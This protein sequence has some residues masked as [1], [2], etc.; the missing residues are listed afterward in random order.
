MNNRFF[1]ARNNVDHR[2]NTASFGHRKKTPQKLSHGYLQSDSSKASNGL[3]NH[4][5]GAAA[6]IAASKYLGIPWGAT[7]DGYQSVPDIANALEVRGRTDVRPYLRLKQ[8]VKVH[9]TDRLFVSVERL[10][11]RRFRLDGWIQASAVLDLYFIPEDL[12]SHKPEWHVS[13]SKPAI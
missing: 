3:K 11:Y 6:Q 4:Q 1:F 8:N 5:R 13:L 7:V 12:D 10:G 2:R 9:K